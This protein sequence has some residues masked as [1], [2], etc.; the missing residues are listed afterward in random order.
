MF[1]Q[2][3]PQFRFILSPVSADSLDNVLSFDLC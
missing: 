1:A 2:D 3:R